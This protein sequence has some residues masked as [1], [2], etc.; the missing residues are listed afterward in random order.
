VL[1]IDFSRDAS[2][3]VSFD[4]TRT[5]FHGLSSEDFFPGEPIRF[6]PVTQ[7]V[8]ASAQAIINTFVERLGRI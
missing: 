2:A 4:V 6:R 3:Q 7:G 8:D 1:K 5:S